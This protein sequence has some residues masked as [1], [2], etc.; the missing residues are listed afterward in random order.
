[1]NRPY[2]PLF[3]DD[4]CR[5]WHGLYQGWLALAEIHRRENECR[6]GN[7]SLLAILTGR[8]SQSTR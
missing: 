6:K 5:K 1:M 4:L 8:A 7:S 3:R 2:Q